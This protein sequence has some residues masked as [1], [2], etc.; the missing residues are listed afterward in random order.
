M[1]KDKSPC[2][3]FRWSLPCVSVVLSQP[4]LGLKIVNTLQS[5]RDDT[6]CLKVGREYLKGLTFLKWLYE[7]LKKLSQRQE[8]RRQSIK[9]MKQRETSSRKIQNLDRKQCKCD[10]RD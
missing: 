7:S 8:T 3:C 9:F 1:L 2:L 6:I 10:S 4:G 5:L